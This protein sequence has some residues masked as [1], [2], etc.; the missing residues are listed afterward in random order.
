MPD[1]TSTAN[2]R[3]KNLV[4]LR[5][6]RHRDA[7]GVTLVE[8]HDELSLA[9]DAGVRPTE[10]YWAPDLVRSEELLERM[11]GAR[12]TSVTREVFARIAYRES[13]DGWLA[14][15]PAP[16]RPL[17]ELELRP[18]A[19][20]LVAEGIEKPGNVGAMLRTAE[21]CG[22]DA[23]VIATPDRAGTDF[24]NPN[25]VRAS[26]GTVF[27]VPVASA[28]TAE[29]QE[30]LRRRGVRSVVTTPAG[31]TELGRADLTGPTALV[32][33]TE[34]TGVTGPWLAGADATV[35]IPM[36][37]TVNSLNASIAAAVVLFEAV[38]Q[39]SGTSAG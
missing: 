9:L 33:G 11:P 37:G 15:A 14:V 36:R 13:P 1:L 32:I 4:R 39:R 17:D 5:T 30:W 24:A 29:V 28:P 25:V 10:V 18:D 2:P 31:T 35:V 12:A 8:G 3:V 26:K 7:A 23:V 20:V 34:A 19:L 6:R 21:A 16:G 22:V 38:R 27:A